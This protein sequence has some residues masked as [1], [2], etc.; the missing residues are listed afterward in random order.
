MSFEEVLVCATRT[1]FPG[2][3]AVSV[4]GKQLC[5]IKKETVKVI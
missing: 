3:K 5:S 2:S 4:L 1:L